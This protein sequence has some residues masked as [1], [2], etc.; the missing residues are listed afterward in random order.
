MRSSLYGKSDYFLRIKRKPV[1]EELYQKVISGNLTDEEIENCGQP[2]WVREALTEIKTRGGKTQWQVVDQVIARTE[3]AQAMA[4]LQEYSVYEWK[5]ANELIV[6]PKGFDYEIEPGNLFLADPIRAQ[7]KIEYTVLNIS[8]VKMQE[9]IDASVFLGRY[10][11]PGY[12][13]LLTMRR[14]LR[15]LSDS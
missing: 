15:G 2:L 6:P 4:A 11:D 9:M 12:V 13:E 5:K 8:H 1:Q 7:V 3:A 10:T 14:K